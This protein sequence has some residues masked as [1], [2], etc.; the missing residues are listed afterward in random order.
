MSERV[1]RQ[2]VKSFHELIAWQKAMLLAEL[3]YR[4]TATFP[5]S[6]GFGLVGQMRRAAVSIPSNIAEGQSRNTPGE[7]LQS[8]GHARGSLAELDTQSR[9]AARLGYIGGRDVESIGQLIAETG[10]LLNG[11]RNSLRRKSPHTSH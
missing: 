10:R 2:P 1:A 11:L 9:L 6:E 8:L 3:V 4:T 5:K 7:M